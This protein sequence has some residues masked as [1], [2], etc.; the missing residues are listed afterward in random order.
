[1]DQQFFLMFTIYFERERESM[2]GGGT[3]REGKGESQ[4]DSLEPDPGQSHKLQD[5][6]LTQNQESDTQVTEPSRWTMDQQFFLIFFI[7]ERQSTRGGGAKREGDT[8]SQSGSRLIAVSTEC[9]MGLECTKGKIMTWAE[10]GCLTD[11]ATQVPLD[12]Q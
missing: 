5:H 2:H 6:D 8:Q 11:W 12:Q 3:K 9:E 10:V 7:S 1:M 4:A